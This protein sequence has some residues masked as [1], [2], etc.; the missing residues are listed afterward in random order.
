MKEIF[1]VIIVVLFVWMIYATITDRKKAKNGLTVRSNLPIDVIDSAVKSTLSEWKDAEGPGDINKEPR[2]KQG[3]GHPTLS[4]AYESEQGATTVS[5]WM[6]RG[7]NGDDD[8]KILKKM[9]EI[10]QIIQ[11][12]S[13]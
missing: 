9:E 4:V 5:I 7:G 10:A 2:F 13:A 1:G 3:L 8:P 6:S 11:G 12:L